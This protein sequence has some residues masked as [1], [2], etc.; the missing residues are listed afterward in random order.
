MKSCLSPSIKKISPEFVRAVCG[1][2]FL[3]SICQ[4]SRLTRYL[5][6]PI[7][8]LRYSINQLANCQ[9]MDERRKMNITSLALWFIGLPMIPGPS[10]WAGSQGQAPLQCP[11]FWTLQPSRWDHLVSQG[12][13]TSP[14]LSAQT[15]PSM[16]GRCTR[17]FQSPVLHSSACWL[18]IHG[19]KKDDEC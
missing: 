4:M 14:L 13:H 15:L 9:Y 3:F 11:G 12:W 16:H 19:Q 18:S 2:F 17:F 1:E 10:R 5:Q 8:I 7:C 6:S